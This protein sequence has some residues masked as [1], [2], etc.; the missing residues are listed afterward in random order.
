MQ[1]NSVFQLGPKKSVTVV[2]GAYRSS[3]TENA[4]FLIY[5][6]LI[7]INTWFLGQWGKKKD[8]IGT[9]SLI[10]LPTKPEAKKQHIFH[11]SNDT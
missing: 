2:L 9:H 10:P 8:F 1:G 5:K 6:E 4:S 3:A 7:P 11:V